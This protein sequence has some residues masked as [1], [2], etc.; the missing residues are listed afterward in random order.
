M[1]NR[2]IT[3]GTTYAVSR[4]ELP[5]GVRVWNPDPAGFSC[6][7]R[8]CVLLS[9]HDKEHGRIWWLRS[10]N[11]IPCSLGGLCQRPPQSPASGAVR[12]QRLSCC[13][14]SVFSGISG[15][16]VVLQSLNTLS[17][18]C[19]RLVRWLRL[20]VPWRWSNPSA[21]S[22]QVTLARVCLGFEYLQEW[23]HPGGGR[24]DNRVL[25]DIAGSFCCVPER[26]LSSSK[27]VFCLNWDKVL[28]D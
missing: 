6:Q 21:C 16:S 9:T 17:T 14:L 24:E 4:E 27:F 19:R 20:E 23:R 11:S 25:E 22:K 26:R 3:S 7:L 28:Q 8:S 15:F 1:S 12:N 2:R 13:R 5:H 18:C 10:R